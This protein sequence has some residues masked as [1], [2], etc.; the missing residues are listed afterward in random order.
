ME[1]QV[2]HLTEH[3]V[4]HLRHLQNPCKQRGFRR[5]QK[6]RVEHLVEHLMEHLVEH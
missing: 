2:E 3:Q 5:V 6:S 1:H 4:E